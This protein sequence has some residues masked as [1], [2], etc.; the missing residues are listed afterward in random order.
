MSKAINAEKS[1]AKAVV[2]MDN[3]VANDDTL[4]D[5]VDDGSH[6]TTQISAFFL[7]GKDGL[8]E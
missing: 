7:L 3:N 6:R 4:I 5:M 8:V 2:V 1:G